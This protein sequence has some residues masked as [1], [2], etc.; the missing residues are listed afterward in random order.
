MASPGSDHG[1]RTPRPLSTIQSLA[2]ASQFGV[3]LAVAVGVGLLLGQWLD[4]RLGTG[5]VFTLIGAL[6]GLASGV[7][8][9]LRIYRASLRVSGSGEKPRTTASARALAD[10]DHSTP[11]N[12]PPTN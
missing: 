2:I 7:M 5:I 4:A 3:T 10:E 9:A 12:E 11:T 6:L 8:A 1:E